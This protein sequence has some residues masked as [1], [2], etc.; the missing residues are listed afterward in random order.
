MSIYKRGD[1]WGVDVCFPDNRRIKEIIGNKKQAEAVETKLKQEILEI[2]WQVRFLPKIKFNNFLKEYLNY[3]KK[4]QSQSTFNSNQ[5]R[6][7]KH[8]LPYF[9]KIPLVYITQK[10]VDAYK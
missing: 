4:N 6:I 10:K 9:N 1:K 2:K 8:I 3:I 7:K 5:Y